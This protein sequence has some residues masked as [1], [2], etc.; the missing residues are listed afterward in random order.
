MLGHPDVPRVRCVLHTHEY[1][2]LFYHQFEF[3]TLRETVHE[4]VMLRP[5][6]G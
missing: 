5:R 3:E 6:P 1:T 4:T 2:A